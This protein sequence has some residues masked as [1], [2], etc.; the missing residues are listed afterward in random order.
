[1]NKELLTAFGWRVYNTFKTV[2][3]PVGGLVVLIQLRETPDSLDVLT[4]WALW[5]SVL[6]AVLT[7]LLGSLVAGAEKVIRTIKG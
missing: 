7:T 4:T 5:E 6:Y 3:L 1:M 2:I